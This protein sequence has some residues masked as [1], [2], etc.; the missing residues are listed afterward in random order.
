MLSQIVFRIPIPKFRFEIMVLTWR[1]PQKML[2]F[3]LKWGKIFFEFLELA[4]GVMTPW[5][6]LNAKNEDKLKNCFSFDQVKK[7]FCPFKG[8]QKILKNKFQILFLLFF[9]VQGRC[10]PIFIKILIFK[11]TSGQIC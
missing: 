4:T 1:S 10:F 2:T 8:L 11:C 6:F 5:N 3:T 9:E 7:K